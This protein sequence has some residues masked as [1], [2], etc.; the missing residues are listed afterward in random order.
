[1]SCCRRKALLADNRASGMSDLRSLLEQTG[2]ECH[3]VSSIE[4][5]RMELENDSFDLFLSPIRLADG[6]AYQIIPLLAGSSC[7]AFFA[8]PIR[9]ACFWIPAVDRGKECLG[10]AAL[11]PREFRVVLEGIAG[12]N[13]GNS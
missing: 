2:F 1:M 4:E 9:R 12:L 8:F 11:R 13:N 7:A 10:S 6:N 5:V 3:I